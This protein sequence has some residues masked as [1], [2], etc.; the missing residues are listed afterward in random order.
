MLNGHFLLLLL[1]S[2]ISN[3][4]SKCEIKAAYVK[5]NE[6]VIGTRSHKAM[7]YAMSD[8]NKGIMKNQEELFPNLVDRDC[9]MSLQVYNAEANAEGSVK[10]AEEM[11]EKFY[12]HKITSP[13]TL[14]MQYSGL[15]MAIS[16]TI[17][18][19]NLAQFSGFATNPALTDYSHFFRNIA[20]DTI[21]TQA[22]IK[23]CN[24][25]GW[26]DI[27]LFHMTSGAAFKDSLTKYGQKG[28]VKVTPFEFVEEAKDVE[29]ITAQVDA[30]KNS[31]LNIFVLQ[32]YDADLEIMI[33]AMLKNGMISE[34]N[35]EVQWGSYYF[36][37][38]DGFLDS[39]TIA[40]NK[41]I[42]KYLSGTVGTCQS[43]F[44]EFDAILDVHPE[45]VKKSK[46]EAKALR[47]SADETNV[48]IERHGKYVNDM[49]PYA[50][51]Q[52]TTL[53]LATEQYITKHGDEFLVDGELEEYVEDI[54][55]LNVFTKRFMHILKKVKFNGITGDVAF[56][57][58]GDRKNGLVAYC[59]FGI[60]ADGS[61]QYNTIGFYLDGQK[62]AIIDTDAIL[63]NPSYINTPS[64]KKT[65][66]PTAGPGTDSN[67]SYL[68]TMCVAFLIFAF[69]FMRR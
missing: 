44:S 6:L 9:K 54:D 23:L 50:Y 20:S 38:F 5:L 27:G 13:I 34:E 47:A 8:F 64:D 40:G 66:A 7:K 28:N 61:Y 41:K 58:K 16:D 3:A 42:K 31:G 37:G 46:K 26:E 11:V 19:A 35:G 15:S 53:L 25:M 51:D 21:Q 17:K 1:L 12:S 63:Y 68:I 59:N 48:L 60:D 36:V 24:K 52:I 56:D 45:F 62:E 67:S 69:I 22:L 29:S 18:D 43:A 49:L 65:D 57:K 10:A 33:D 55:G 30:M 4:T 2:L 14:A 32:A 39:A